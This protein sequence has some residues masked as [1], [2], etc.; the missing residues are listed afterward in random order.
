MT[1]ETIEKMIRLTNKIKVDGKV[2][3]YA[4]GKWS[5]LSND[6]FKSLLR[7]VARNKGDKAIKAYYRGSWV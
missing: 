5:G 4:N 1:N 3:Q 7:L 2:Y 6:D